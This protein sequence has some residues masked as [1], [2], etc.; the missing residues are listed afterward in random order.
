VICALILAAGRSSRMGVPKPLLDFGGAPCLEIVRE[1]CLE[2]GI[3]RQVVVLG[4]KAR[5]IREAVS[6]DGASVI[7]NPSW[8]RGMICS[9]Q[10]GLSRLPRD[11][12]AFFLFPV[13]YPLVRAN[14]LRSLVSRFRSNGSAV[15]LP[16]CEGRRGHPVLFDRSLVREFLHLGAGE[17]ARDV[18]HR[19]ESELLEVETDDRG[20]LQELN[21]PDQYRAALEAFR[22]RSESPL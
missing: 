8:R 3:D 10:I 1:T 5:D 17:T 19:H 12:D 20:V 14:T 22:Q 21:T 6:L 16:S 7:T 2:A 13:D 11:A 4:H 15:V 9:I 18:V